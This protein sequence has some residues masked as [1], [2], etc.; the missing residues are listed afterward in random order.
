MNETAML[1]VAIGFAVFLAGGLARAYMDFAA[2]GRRMFYLLRRGSTES[3]Y[4]KLI[5]ERR[6]SVWPLVLSSTC[7]PLGILIVFG[8]IIWNN[9]LRR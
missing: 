3:N 6:A 2:N 4:R 8:S 1:G 9:H 5:K 7:I